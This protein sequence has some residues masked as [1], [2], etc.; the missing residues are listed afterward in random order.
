MKPTRLFSY[1][2][3]A[4]CLILSNSG[5]FAQETKRK[6]ATVTAQVS[7]IRSDKGLVLAALFCK[8]D[9]FPDGN[10]ACRRAATKI[11]NG[12]AKVVFTNVPPGVYAVSLIHDENSNR[13]LETNW[14]GIPDEGVGVSRNATGTMGPPDYED[15]SFRVRD[16]SILLRIRMFYY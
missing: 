6:N 9:G 14:I 8:E 12:K 3:V 10:K 5:T 11:S 13:K 16:K 2:W 1:Y 15:A 4:L 7:G